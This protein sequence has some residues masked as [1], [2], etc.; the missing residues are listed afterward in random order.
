[1]TMLQDGLEKAKQGVT[2]VEEL[3]RVLAQHA[4]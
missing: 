3:V 4:R 1:V 2:T